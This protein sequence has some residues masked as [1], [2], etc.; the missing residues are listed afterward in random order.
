M[1][2]GANLFCL[3]RSDACSFEMVPWSVIKVQEYKLFSVILLEWS[4]LKIY[5]DWDD[6]SQRELKSLQKR[7]Y[8]LND[9]CKYCFSCLICY[10]NLLIISFLFPIAIFVFACSEMRCARGLNVYFIRLYNV[11]FWDLPWKKPQVCENVEIW[12]A[13]LAMVRWKSMNS[14]SGW[15][16]YHPFS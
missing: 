1:S 4:F 13:D 8:N 6:H 15:K 7:T 11:I 9:F 10:L 14:F 3:W 16:C 12:N 5:N 2:F